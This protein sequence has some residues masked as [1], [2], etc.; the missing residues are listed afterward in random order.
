M[1]LSACFL[2]T[3]FVVVRVRQETVVKRGVL[4]VY[5]QPPALAVK[6]A[7]G[8]Q[9]PAQAQQACRHRLK[10]SNGLTTA[11]SW[12]MKGSGAYFLQDRDVFQEWLCKKQ[13]IGG[14]A[15]PGNIIV[16]ADDQTGTGFGAR[17]LRYTSAL[18]TSL[19][20]GKI[21]V[22][23]V[24]GRWTYS[25]CQS[26]N[27]DCYFM[28]ISNISTDINT[29]DGVD[30]S[31][32]ALFT[33]EVQPVQTLLWT[34]GSLD[35][36]Y[37]NHGIGVAWAKSLPKVPRGRGGCWVIGQL[38]YFLLHPNSRLER[39]L[40]EEKVRLNWGHHPVAAF[41]VRHGDRAQRGHAGS[42]LQLKDFISSLR[43]MAPHVKH[44][45]FS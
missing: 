19:H 28:P 29:P 22:N 16:F 5:R 33:P 15:L 23:P 39:V 34:R 32:G 44:G 14:L 7:S 13:H 8:E 45:K 38:A 11:D 1:Q 36:F 18:L 30:R 17:L 37:S 41:H 31:A 35:A 6:R 3:F 26:K 9:R 40:Q 21:L 24:V 20:F 12:K 25:K 2:L 42:S 27:N 4:G 43:S 10:V